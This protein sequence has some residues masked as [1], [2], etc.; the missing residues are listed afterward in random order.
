M[1]DKIKVATAVLCGCFGCHISFF[2]FDETM[3]EHLKS[4]KL[5]K[6]PMD[7]IKELGEC[8]FGLLEGGCCNEENVRILKEFRSKCRYLVTVGDCANDGGYDL[9]RN[10][11]PIS[12]LLDEAFVSGITVGKKGIPDDPELPKLLD[13][14]VPCREVVKV[15]FHIPG[16][17]PSSK[18]VMDALQAIAEG[19][20]ISELGSLVRVK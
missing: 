17:P 2:D 7:D 14:V 15:D 8:D 20:D 3:L 16:C 6:S 5:D 12:E 10:D 4:I 19:K 9:L 13:K 11:I 18:T 1:S